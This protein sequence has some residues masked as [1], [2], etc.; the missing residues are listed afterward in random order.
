MTILT[1]AWHA[2][3]PELLYHYLR[4]CPD[5]LAGAILTPGLDGC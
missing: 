1:T 5:H 2:A 4:V 3:H